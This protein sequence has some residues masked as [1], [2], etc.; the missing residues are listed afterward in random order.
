MIMQLYSNAV[1]SLCIDLNKFLVT[2]DERYEKKV[3]KSGGTMARKTRIVG[4]PSTSP[5]PIGAAEWTIANGMCNCVLCL[6]KYL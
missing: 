2:L 3:T 5:I 4:V 1:S 6:G